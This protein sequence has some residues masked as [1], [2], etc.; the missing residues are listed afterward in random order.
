MGYNLRADVSYL[1]LNRD[2]SLLNRE[3][4]LDTPGLFGSCALDKPSSRCL[5][6]AVPLWKVLRAGM[7]RVPSLDG[8]GILELV[9]ELNSE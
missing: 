1:L 2:V 4:L 3:G 6:R 5:S 8:T 9:V 7:L